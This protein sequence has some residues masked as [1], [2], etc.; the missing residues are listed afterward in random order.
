MEFKDYYK[1]LGVARDAG[2]DE[3]KKAYRRLARKYHP[4]VSKEAD[5]A[6]RMAEVNEANAVLSDPEKRAAYD[7]LGSAGAHA[8][9]QGFR[10]PPH[11]DAGY[12]FSD[13]PGGAGGM[14][15]AQFSDFFEQLFGRA[16][17][18]RRGQGRASGSSAQRGA[19][20]HAR[21]ELDLRDAYQGG[22]RLLTL[23]GA[24]LDAQGHLVHEERQ[25]QVSIPKGVREGQLIR[26]S[27]QGGPG[28]NG[29]PAGDLFLEVL[30]K[31]DAR[32]RTQDRDVYLSVPVAPWEAE[33]GGPIE[34]RTPGGAT[35]Q[36]TVPARFKS[37]RKLRLKER[38]IP[39]ATPGDLYLELQV[40]LPPAETP[41]QQQAYRALAEA[42]PQFAPRTAAGV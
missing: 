10:P 40:A 26:L 4:D 5:A 9:A 3:I 11:W 30:F 20:H 16:A 18:A 1:I 6:A 24:R 39:A 34:V 27:G 14:D 15:E 2:S 12:E 19:D 28:L 29:A 32:W 31:P 25:V 38:G 21:I 37:G 22:E 7:A 41:A 13:A 36:V 35:V 23:Q 17:Q 8:G 33:L 42:F